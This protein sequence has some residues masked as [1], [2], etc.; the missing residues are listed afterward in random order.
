MVFGQLETSPTAD[1]HRHVCHSTTVTVAA[2]CVHE[3]GKLHLLI[4]PT[5]LTAAYI[6]VRAHSEQLFMNKHCTPSPKREQRHR[7]T[8]GVG[9]RRK[10]IHI[11]LDLNW[12]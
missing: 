4:K 9:W 8:V 2:Y 5:T 7:P 10:V 12:L 3:D 1:M 6:Y 11:A